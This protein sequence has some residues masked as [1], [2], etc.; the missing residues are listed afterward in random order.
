MA[1]PNKIIAKIIALV[2]FPFPS[3][4][5]R[6]PFSFLDLVMLENITASRT[7]RLLSYS[8]VTD[9]NGCWTLAIHKNNISQ[10]LKL[11]VSYDRRSVLS[12]RIWFSCM[13]TLGKAVKP[14]ELQIC[15]C[16]NATCHMHT[17][18]LIQFLAVTVI[19]FIFDPKT[20]A[21]LKGMRVNKINVIFYITISILTWQQSYFIYIFFI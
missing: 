12:P 16:M 7:W 3:R 20:T 17:A 8:S 1:F 18:I 11:Y 19:G 10:R 5:K 21:Y 4:V 13:S 6:L 2:Y 14:R 9:Q 15:R